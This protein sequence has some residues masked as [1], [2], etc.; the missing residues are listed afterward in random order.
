MAVITRNANPI[1]WQETR[2]QQRM[3]QPFMRRYWLPLVLGVV[4]IIAAIALTLQSV[5]NRTRDYAIY[6]IWI[7]HALVAARALA[8]GAN[9]ISREHVGKTWDA[10]VLTGVSQRRILLGKWLGILHLTAPWMLLLGVVRLSM[11]PILMMAFLNRYAWFNSSRGGSYYPGV[12][13]TVDWVEWAALSAVAFTVILTVLE[14]LACSAIGLACS[15]T[16]RRGWLAMVVAVGVRFTPVV[17]FGIFT[18]YEMDGRPTWQLLRFPALSLADSGTSTVYQLILPYTT[19]TAGE[20][21]EALPGAFMAV[22]L[23][24]AL[25]IGALAV[26]WWAIRR[27]GALPHPVPQ[28]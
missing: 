12:M 9:A 28:P 27:D 26:S 18:R 15:A 21:I 1:E 13:P 14:V 20:H 23:L 24:L 16:I 19:W 5:N 8:A 4:I 7:T 2:Y 3:A 6:T 22:V 25:L 17:L 11:L 10:L